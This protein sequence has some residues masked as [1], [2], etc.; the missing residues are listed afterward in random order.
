MSGVFFND[1]PTPP[2]A[3]VQ[4]TLLSWLTPPV[5]RHCCHLPAGDSGFDFYL[6]PGTLLSLLT[7]MLSLRTSRA[8]RQH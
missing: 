3:W 2:F 7:L 6:P 4:A 5:Q 8:P 1:I